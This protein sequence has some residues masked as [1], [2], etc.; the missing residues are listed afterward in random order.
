MRQ[1]IGTL[2]LLNSRPSQ[3]EL[4]LAESHY[5]ANVTIN[6]LLFMESFVEDLLNLHM[7]TAGKFKLENKQFD[8]QKAINFVCD[9]I[10]MMAE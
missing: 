4:E 10:S 1:I 6:Q 2:K 8:P 9:M 5:T 3:Y 7:M